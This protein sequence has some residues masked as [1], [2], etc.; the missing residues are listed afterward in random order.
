MVHLYDQDAEEIVYA[1]PAVGG[2]QTA[3][4][5]TAQQFGKKATIFVAKRAQPHQRA[6]MAKRL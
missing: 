1:S 3:L 2:A 6:L 5:W 4:A